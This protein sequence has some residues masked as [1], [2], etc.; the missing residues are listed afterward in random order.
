VDLAF[1]TGPG[2]RSVISGELSPSAA[3]EDGTVRVLSGDPSLLDRFAHT[4][5]LAARSAHLSASA[6]LARPS[7]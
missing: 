2:I 3:V 1:E 4:F 6:D 5:H 7:P